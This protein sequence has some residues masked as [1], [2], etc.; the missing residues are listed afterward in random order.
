MFAGNDK[1]KVLKK[2]QIYGI[3]LVHAIVIIPA[4]SLLSFTL[5]DI[6]ITL[7]DGWLKLIIEIVVRLLF[8]LIVFRLLYKGSMKISKGKFPSNFPSS[9]KE[10]AS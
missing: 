9:K 10:S 7:S 4:V 5:N 2:R 6:M 1:I 3:A 8:I